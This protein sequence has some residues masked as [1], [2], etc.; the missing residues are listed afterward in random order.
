MRSGIYGPLS[1][2]VRFPPFPFLL[3]A[4]IL[5]SLCFRSNIVNTQTECHPVGPGQRK[6]TSTQRVEPL[7]SSSS[8]RDECR[9]AFYIITSCDAIKRERVGGKNV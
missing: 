5:P 9:E 4:S 8:R 2:A 7:S 1:E 3:S 6:V